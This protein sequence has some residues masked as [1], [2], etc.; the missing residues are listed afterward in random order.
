MHRLFLCIKMTVMDDIGSI[1]F[2]QK[3]TRLSPVLL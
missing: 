3:Q 1:A 2:Y